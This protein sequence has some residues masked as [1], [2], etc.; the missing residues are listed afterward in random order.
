MPVEKGCEGFSKFH[1]SFLGIWE[2]EV[3]H[4]CM[5]CIITSPLAV[6]LQDSLALVE[7]DRGPVRAVEVEEEGLEVEY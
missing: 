4:W 2:L 1:Q 3:E 6:L 7:E 5:P